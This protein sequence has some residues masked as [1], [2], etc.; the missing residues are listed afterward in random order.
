LGERSWQIYEFKVS[1]IYRVSF[2]TAKTTQRVTLP[3]QI[4]TTM[5]MMMGRRRK[6]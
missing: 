2:R 5:M 3:Q 4:T 1:L 6:Q